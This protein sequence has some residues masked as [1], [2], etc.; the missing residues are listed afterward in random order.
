MPRILEGGPAAPPPVQP[1]TA[2]L[3]Q[4][5]DES[6]PQPYFIFEEEVPR[7]GTI[8]M[9]SYERTRWS[10]GRVFVWLRVRRQTGRGEGSSG[11]RFD[12]IIDVPEQSA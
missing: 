9:L 2:L 12:E 7:A 4:G 8:A 3:R 10:D 6:L 5:L 1:H 11:L